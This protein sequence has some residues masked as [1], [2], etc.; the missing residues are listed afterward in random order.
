MKVLILAFLTCSCG[1][2]FK[3]KGKEP[4]KVDTTVNIDVKF[5][6]AAEFCDQRYGYKTVEAEKCFN[7]YRT[8]T[9]VLGTVGAVDVDQ[10]CSQYT[11]PIQ[12][13]ECEANI[14]DIILG[15]K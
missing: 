11:D 8:Y 3:I 7:D 5:K 4:I 14:N 2:D 6:E 13:A 9:K 12:Q 15:Q 1:M 10:F